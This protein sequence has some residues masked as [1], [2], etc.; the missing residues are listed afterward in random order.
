MHISS[1]GISALLTRKKRKQKEGEHTGHTVV[2]TLLT[3][4][5]CVNSDDLL[6]SVRLKFSSVLF[7]KRKRVNVRKICRNTT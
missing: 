6:V 4:A 3:C 5:Y 2:T 7:Y 1:H